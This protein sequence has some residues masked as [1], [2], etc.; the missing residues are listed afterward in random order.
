MTAPAAATATTITM[1]RSD[2]W[3]DLIDDLWGMYETA[4]TGVNE[5]A[6]QRHLMTGDEFRHVMYDY[7]VQKH[8]AR[9][10]TGRVVGQS[11]I[12]NS[13]D[14]WPLISPAYFRKWW[15]DLYA[16]QRIWYVGYVCTAPDAPHHVFRD[17]IAD[18]AGPVFEGEGMAVMDFCAW[19]EGRRLPD[20]TTRILN[21]LNPRTAHAHI[22][23]QSFHA[24]RF[25]GRGV[26]PRND[27]LDEVPA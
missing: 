16:R 13:L 24:W 2:L 22:D 7:P 21:R 19:N 26:F 18:M 10:S 5:L 11:V 14:A 20:A 23:T 6:A 8:V 9:D 15:P 25:D 1:H 12:T 17:L 3:P 4:F 27:G